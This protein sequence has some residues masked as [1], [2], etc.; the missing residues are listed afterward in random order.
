MCTESSSLLFL[1]LYSRCNVGLKLLKPNFA[2]FYVNMVI[3]RNGYVNMSSLSHAPNPNCLQPHPGV[4]WT[5]KN[6][7][8]MFELW[9]S[10]SIGQSSRSKPLYSAWYPLA[11]KNCQDLYPTKASKS[12]LQGDD[13]LPFLL[14][15][16][17]N[18]LQT[19]V[20]GTQGPATG[21]ALNCTKCFS[22]LFFLWLTAGTG[23][24]L[25]FF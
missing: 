4:S 1:P 3:M 14:D 19:A 2:N 5:L 21:R 6:V 15:K 12:P 17:L 23:S 8:L 11:V 9:P 10:G 13:V 18:C 16:E 24:K 25:N 20:P 22:S 7:K